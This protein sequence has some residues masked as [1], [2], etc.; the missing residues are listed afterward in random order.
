MARPTADTEYL[1]DVWTRINSVFAEQKVA[2]YKVAKK[3]VP[4]VGSSATYTTLPSLNIEIPVV[5]PPISTIA[6][7]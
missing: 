2:K 7:F 6:P 5:P 3:C 4:P 1:S